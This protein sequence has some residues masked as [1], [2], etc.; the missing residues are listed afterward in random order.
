MNDDIVTRLRESVKNI[1]A[2]YSAA[3]GKWAMEEAAD[4]IQRLRA[5]NAFLRKALVR[6]GC[7]YVDIISAVTEWSENE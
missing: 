2:D 5:E 3:T 4:E 6:Y 1:W 7:E